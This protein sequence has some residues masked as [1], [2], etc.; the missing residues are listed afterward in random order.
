MVDIIGLLLPI[1]AIIALGRAVVWLALI[2]APRIRGISDFTYWIALPALLFGSIAEGKAPDL[3]GV[4]A[5]YLAG[6]LLVF[7]LALLLA[8]ILLQMWLPQA[9]AFALT[10]T[11]GSAIYFG[12]PIVSAAFGPSGLVLLLPIVAL[13]SG[14][15]LPL[16]SALIENG[17]PSRTDSVLRGTLR[18][19]LRNPIIIAI[20]VGFLWHAGM[21]VSAPALAFFTLLGKAATP[22]ALFCVGASLPTTTSGSAREAALAAVLKLAVLPAVIAAGALSVGL[23][24][25]P[26]KIA[27]ITAAMPT[28]PNAF[29]LAR[30]APAFADTS[31][32]TVVITLIG[33]LP[34]L[35]GLLFWLG[36]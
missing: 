16:A 26:V 1:F 11:Y 7:G 2:D 4:A 3:L 31:A 25:L 35:S 14:I 33:A 22:L 15:L 29:L 30:R 9:A 6:C 18:N 8:R 27:L 21:P 12:I 34:I 13:H 36:Q 32:L 19:L 23:S 5:V 28:G 20:A 17:T 10:A 24:G